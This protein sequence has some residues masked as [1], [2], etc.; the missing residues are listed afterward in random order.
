MGKSIK[1]IGREAFSG[2]KRVTDIYCYAER[3]PDAMSGDNDSFEG[4]SRKAYLWV[5][6][7]RLRNY[8]T[9]EYWG[10]F[11]VRAMEAESANTDHVVV[12][13]ENNTAEIIWPASGS[14]ESYELTIKDRSGN[15][16]CTLV[17]NAQGQLQS[18]VFRAP[19]ADGSRAPESVQETGFRF[20]VTGLDE[21]TQYDYSIVVKDIADNIIETYNGSFRTNGG[22]TGI[23]DSILQDDASVSVRK[24]LRNGQVIII[25][26]NG[27][28]FDIAGKKID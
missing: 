16:I 13:P 4:V 20:T 5:P 14:A 1:E 24:I 28:K 26:P 3:V 6:A 18:I 11:D 10:E 27:D 9:D 12:N 2:C 21:G 7:N 23:E 22:E 8:Q 17:F 25:M 15:E 19:A